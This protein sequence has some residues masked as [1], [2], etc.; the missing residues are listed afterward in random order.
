MLMRLSK[1]QMAEMLADM[2]SKE[3]QVDREG[4]NRGYDVGLN[5]AKLE[6]EYGSFDALV[7]N[8]LA[9]AREEMPCSARLSEAIVAYDSRYLS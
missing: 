4:Y 5:M 6:T 9:A 3:D 2:I 1:S 7:Q 8:V